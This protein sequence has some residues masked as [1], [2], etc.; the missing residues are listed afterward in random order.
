MPQD[1]MEVAQANSS[2]PQEV[3]SHLIQ[4]SDSVDVELH[5]FRASIR[6]EEEALPPLE[7]YTPD[8]QG[9]YYCSWEDCGQVVLGR[10]DLR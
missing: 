9:F 7:N 2:G 5:T 3:E 8:L 4:D 1:D 6:F 10:R